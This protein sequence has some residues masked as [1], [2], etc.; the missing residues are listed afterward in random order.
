MT[1]TPTRADAPQAREALTRVRAEVAK[2]VVGQDA[3]VAGLLVGLLALLSCQARTVVIVSLSGLPET[4]CR[5][6]VSAQTDAAF[7]AHDFT[8]DLVTGCCGIDLER[9]GAPE[10]GHVGAT[11]AG[12]SHAHQGLPS[13]RLGHGRLNDV[14]VTR[15]TEQYGFHREE[16]PRERAQRQ[17]PRCADPWTIR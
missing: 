15:G 16:P 11:D 2:A 1:E 6:R 12:G 14:D 17:R 13:G 10:G 5:V 3:A 4:A 8:S 9:R 7:P